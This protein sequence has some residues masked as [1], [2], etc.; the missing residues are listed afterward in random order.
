MRKK[1]KLDLPPKA[2]GKGGIA[3]VFDLSALDVDSVDVGSDGFDQK[4]RLTFHYENID[5]P[6]GISKDSLKVASFIES[7]GGWKG[8]PD[9]AVVG[10]DTVGNTIIVEVDHF[11]LWSVIDGDSVEAGETIT[12]PLLE[13]FSLISPPVEPESTITSHTLL[14]L[15]PNSREIDRWN[16]AASLFESVIRASD[17]TVITDPANAFDVTAPEGFFVKVIAASEVTFRGSPIRV[18]VTLTLGKGFNIVGVPFPLGFTSH[19][20]LPLI[21]NAREIDRWN[22]AASLFESAI[23]TADGTVITDP[24]DAFS[25]ELGEGYFVKVL[26]FSEFTPPVSAPKAIAPEPHELEH[27]RFEEEVSANVFPFEVKVSNVTDLAATVSWISAEN[28]LAQV[29]YGTDPDFS[30]YDIAYDVRGVE[31][32]DDIHWVDIIGLTPDTKYYYRIL[33]VDPNGKSEDEVRSFTTTPLLNSIPYPYAIYGKVVEDGGKEISDRGVLYAT[34]IHKGK[35]SY[36]ISAATSASAY[37][38]INLGNLRDRESGDLFR[39]LSGDEIVLEY[40]GPSGRYGT[41]KVE[42][43]TD[44]PQDIGE[45]ILTETI[46]LGVPSLDRNDNSHIPQVY[47]LYPNFPNPFNPETV[48]HYDLPVQSHVELSVYNMIGQKVATLVNEQMD[49]GSHSVF[50]DGKDDNGESLASGVYLYRL[51][52]DGSEEFVKIRKLVLMR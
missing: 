15:I 4:V 49:A 19:T 10:T 42:M 6:P 21:P 27:R 36:P 40:Y 9:S 43:G 28:H 33:P 52:T 18:P 44:T 23:R 2:K 25:I 29:Q 13:G 24:T 26:A 20:L 46:T 5:L 7:T 38:S 45:L 50:W 51:K 39:Y 8:V 3:V 14:P 48:I 47:A 16:N 32:P 34:V 31:Y 1:G 30:Y 17:G 41:T 22:N 12:L 37:W 35:E 11:S